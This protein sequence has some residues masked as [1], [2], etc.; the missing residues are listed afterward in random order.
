[1]WGFRKK[2]LAEPTDLRDDYF[3]ERIAEL[4]GQRSLRRLK[5]G[6][7]A[8]M[9]VVVATLGW[10]ARQEAAL[11]EKVVPVVRI[12]G[13]IGASTNLH[14][15][16]LNL[17]RAFAMKSSTVILSIDSPGGDPT[18]AQRI[19]ARLKFL[20]AKNPDKKIVAICERLCASAGYMIA[21]QADEVLAGPYS[22]VGSIGAIIT[23][24]NYSE[25]LGRLGV[26]YKAYSSGD[27]K[28]MLNPFLPT[29]P[30]DEAKA[31]RIVRQLGEGFVAEVRSRRKIAQDVEIDTG[32]IWT[33]EQ[34]KKLGLVDRIAVIEDVAFGDLDGAIP[35]VIDSERRGFSSMVGSFF[36][37]VAVS[38]VA[39]EPSF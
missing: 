27:S 10:Q 5:T 6:V 30:A 20:R 37:D 12:G 15:L 33:A 38:F 39:S 17:E 14:R 3:R 34:A 4:R 7:F 31:K 22:L 11:P 36:K 29:T 13:E 1:M 23:S 8:L 35:V 2:P 21:V 26:H 19:N 25:L 24:M 9:F 28:A 32:E 16:T 18:L